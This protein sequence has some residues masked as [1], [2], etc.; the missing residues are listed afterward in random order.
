MKLICAGFLRGGIIA[1][2]YS[3]ACCA[4]LQ[5]ATHYVWTNSPA[6]TPPFTSWPTAAHT[7]QDALDSAVDGDT[8][9]ATNGLYLLT[10]PVTVTNEVTLRSAN[11]AA[12]TVIDGNGPAPDV[13][14]AI[15]AIIAGRLGMP[16]Q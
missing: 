5:A 3:T 16:G 10:A 4:S 9:L 6:S 7:L 12:S 11:G 14:A 8:V 15:V 13:H 1:A 2:F